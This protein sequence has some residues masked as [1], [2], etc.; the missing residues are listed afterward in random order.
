MKILYVV[1]QG[2]F[3]GAQKY[4]YDLACAAKSRGDD[5]TVAPG[6][7][8]DRTLIKKL[9]ELSISVIE[10]RHLI[11]EISPI[12]DLLA[13]F[14][15]RDLYRKLQPDIIHLNSSKAGIVGPWAKM[16]SGL[17]DSHLVFSVHGW[18]FNEPMGK[19][20][21]KIFIW[22]EKLTP[23]R[24]KFIAVSD[25]DRRAGLRNGVCAEDKIFTIHNGIDIGSV[26]YLPAE[27]AALKLLGRPK[28]EGERLIGTIA[29]FFSTKG[30][31]YL[32]E[33]ADI[34]INQQGL[35][36]TFVVIG[37]GSLRPE[38][39][40][41]ISRLNLKNNFLLPG[42]IENAKSLLPAFDCCA[43]SSVKEGLPYTVL[44]IMAA[45]VPQVATRVGGIAEAIDDKKNGLLV[46]SKNPGALAEAIKFLLDN[47]EA[48]SEMAEQGRRDVLE[49][50]SKERMIDET[51]SVYEEL[52]KNH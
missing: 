40:E 36:A 21:K 10:L 18:Y 11:R 39:E 23:S 48:V 51:W 31:E 47:P 52:I 8:A 30:L 7:S 38:L 44:E 12:N 20:K 26:V 33:A 5:V 32:I 42:R 28:A 2:D 17:P 14:E 46:E 15:L 1:T 13:V 34:L 24:E 49:K 19:L 29:N 41:R 35:K 25:L 37:D 43:L 9:K 4:V 22:L 6:C 45:G 3:G 27:E 16:L 50:F